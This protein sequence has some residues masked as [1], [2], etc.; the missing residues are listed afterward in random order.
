MADYLSSAALSDIASKDT[1]RIVGT[2][3]KT[4]A[5]N[6][7]FL[8]VLNGGT[9]DD[10]SDVVRGVTQEQAMPGD[11][12]AEP[13][14]TNDI[15]SC[16]LDGSAEGVAT[17]EF[18]YQLESKRGRGPKVC[19]KR[20]RAGFKD[21]YLRAED[22]LSKLI[23][24][25]VNSDIRAQLYKRSGSKLV[26]ASDKTFAQLYTGGEG[27]ISVA[28]AAGV[29]PDATL[30]F[31]ALHYL[32]RHM[33]DGLNAEMFQD[34]KFGPHFKF[35]GSSDIVEQ[36]R[37]ETGVENKMIALTTG[38]YKLGETALKAFSFEESPAYRGIAFGVDQ[39]P[40][41]ASAISGAGVPTLVNPVV[42]V[43]TT[44]GTA[45]RTNPA[46]LAAPYEIGFL[47]AKDSF[48]RQ[49]PKQYT[50]E[51][52]FKFAP[53][54]HMGELKWHYVE[55]NNANEWGDFGYHKYQITRAYRPIRPWFVVPIIYRRATA[56]LGFE[57]L[58]TTS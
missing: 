13:T 43:A 14:F 1:N 52:S 57:A 21:S 33:S 31:K 53:Q 32:A 44:K 28:F 12:L 48:E 16:A 47:V 19:V 18:T 50:G 3:A 10:A 20:G 27:Q 29:T 6:S 55:D 39:R 30:N 2:I 35:I 36:F 15:S 46:W 54:L 9:F 40:L 7:P 8:N 56:D 49:T 17:L 58:E 38:G 5:V 26:C 23:T 51:G 45:A 34:G 25:Y 37:N 42:G 4:L 22:S 11:S 41:R 24:Q